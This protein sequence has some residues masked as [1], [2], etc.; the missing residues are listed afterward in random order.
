MSKPGLSFELRPTDNEL[1]YQII[2]NGMTVTFKAS[3]EQAMLE[4]YGEVAGYL[5]GLIGFRKAE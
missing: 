3:S 5:F 2:L 4:R 1:E